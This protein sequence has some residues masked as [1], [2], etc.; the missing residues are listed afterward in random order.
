M[1]V[2][3]YLKSYQANLK[4]SSD[5]ALITF[6]AISN[7][8]NDLGEVFSEKHRPLKL[9]THL[10]NKTTIAHDKPIQK[11]IDAFRDFCIANRD[12][13]ASKDTKSFVKDRISY[14]KRV[15]INMTQIFQQ[16]D[17]ET[18][19]VI[20][21]H[22]LTISALVD[23]TGQARKILKEQA[24]NGGG[25][26]VNFLTDI[27]SKVEGSVNKDANPMEAVASIM[28]SGIF[29][30][31]VSG[32]GNG[33]QDG[34][35][36][37]SKLMGTVQTMVTKLGSD[38]GDQEGGEQAANMINTMMGS[39]TAGANAPTNDGSPQPMPDLA[40]MLGTMMGGLTAG[41]NAPTSTQPMPDLAGMLGAMMG[42]GGNVMPNITG[43][44]G[45]PP[46]GNT[47]EEKINKQ[48]EEA[49]ASGQFPG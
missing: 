13:I 28:Q 20:W 23:P 22:L 27:M 42:G 6:K 1:C 19:N 48:V 40:G 44:L 41:A 32:M 5:T 45:G 25:V 4:M 37:L 26:E 34:S 33:L 36:D 31:L 8:T 7:F 47:I 39:L 17:A 35:L 10:I 24:E 12:S 11:H 49:K 14:S 29:S 43:M 3:T 18:T 30:D 38:S 21:K 2:N 16:S 46:S 15:F 9:Y